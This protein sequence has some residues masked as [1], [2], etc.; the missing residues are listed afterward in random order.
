M[1]PGV[2]R[3]LASRLA[4]ALPIL[5]LVSVL[6]FAVLRLIPIDPLAMSLPPNAT[7]EDIAEMRRDMGFDRPIA[8]Q[9]G[10][11]IARAVRLDFGRSIHHR[12][13]VSSLIGRTLPQTMELAFV[14]VLIAAVL[15]LAGGFYLFHVR[16]RKAETAVDLGTIV[17]LSLPD[18]L[19]GL[20]LI[21][22]CGVAWEILPF[23]GR[24]APEFTRPTVSGFLLL[25]T[26]L[27]G[28]LDMFIDAA[29]HMVLPSLA[30]GISFSPA[31]M[32]ILRSSL[33]D[34]YN[35][36]YI[37]QARLRGVGEV[38]ILLR[39]AAKN[40]IL[41]TL[42]LMGVQFGFL[43]GGTLLIEVIYSYPGMG[44]LMVEAVRNADL[45]LIQAVGLTYCVAVLIINGIV[46]A[47]YLVLNPRL[48]TSS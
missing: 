21:L 47:A 16:E 36:D 37:Q 28:R 29:K 5:F 45:P 2:L 30:L 19:W 39:H 35:E 11:W 46:D 6:L 14:S 1:N 15:G 48:R 34:V 26:L 32:R 12:D 25:D 23:S 27:I 22:L 10:I 41:P 9:Y 43:F 8:E 38:T 33:I 3:L 40:A 31:I 24:L 7:N 18:F 42:T 20:F 44:S 13:E 17:V 4:S